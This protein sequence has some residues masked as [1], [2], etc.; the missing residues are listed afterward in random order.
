M[1]SEQRRSDPKRT[2]I[3]AVHGMGSQ[4]PFD[5]VRGIIDAI[6]LQGQISRRI[7]E[8]DVDSP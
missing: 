8:E 4:R 3:L 1:S 2:A 5:T 6:W 7:G